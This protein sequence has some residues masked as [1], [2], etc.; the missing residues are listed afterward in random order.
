MPGAMSTVSEVSGTIATIATGAVWVKV[1]VQ[2]RGDT[3][4]SYEADAATLAT[5]GAIWPSHWLE[6]FSLYR[7]TTVSAV[8]GAQV[9]SHLIDE[10]DHLDPF[11]G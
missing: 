3:W 8:A 5:V 6:L 11:F 1:K 7:N 2:E 4:V 10:T 9:K